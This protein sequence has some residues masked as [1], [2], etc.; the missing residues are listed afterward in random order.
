VLVLAAGWL[1]GLRRG[2][3]PGI[4]GAAALGILVYL[5]GGPVT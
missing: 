5:V 3:V 2:V 1:I 4:T